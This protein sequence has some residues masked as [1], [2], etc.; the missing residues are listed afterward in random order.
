MWAIDGMR[1]RELLQLGEEVL[2]QGQQDLVAVVLEVVG[3]GPFRVGVE[4]VLEP[5]R[6]VPLDEGGELAEERLAGGRELRP[7][8]TEGEDLFELI[9]DEDRD[10]ETVARAPQLVVRPVEVFPERL[11]GA[12][13]RHSDP[14]GCGV[15]EE[16]VLALGDEVRGGRGVVEPHQDRQEALV[17]EQREEPGLK[18]GALAEAGEPVEHRQ[19]VAPHPAVELVG[20]GRAAVEEG[21]VGLAE[22]GEPRPRVVPVDHALAGGRPGRRLGDHG[23]TPSE[24]W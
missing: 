24:R 15:L 4:P 16:R 17:P 11:A 23:A 13:W 8:A 6:R 9:E 18:E 21:A 10:E 2:P 5:A 22:G 1:P 20:G 14:G 12:P 7:A 19:P 3:A